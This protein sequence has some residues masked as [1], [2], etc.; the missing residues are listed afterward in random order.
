MK[1]IVVMG[2][3]IIFFLSCISEKNVTMDKQT[4]IYELMNQYEVNNPI[5]IY[6]P[7]FNSDTNFV[8]TGMFDEELSNPNKQTLLDIESEIFENLGNVPIETMYV[9]SSLLYNVG[10]KDKAT[11]WFYTAQLYSMVFY[12]IMDQSVNGKIGDYTFELASGLN[13]HNE[14]SGYWINGF[15]FG[16]I[17]QLVFILGLVMENKNILQFERLYPDAK[18]SNLDDAGNIH[19]EKASSLSGFIE[20]LVE[21]RDQ[22]KKDREETG[23][24]DMY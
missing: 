11:Y 14:L 19:F 12:N 6:T 7:F 24:S 16:D 23:I 20:Y 8:E 22:I 18:F 3:S 13:A 21:N 10:Y 17:D 9:L 1:K 15:S 5:S 2:L 4:G